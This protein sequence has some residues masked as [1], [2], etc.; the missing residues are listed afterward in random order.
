MCTTVISIDPHSPVP[1]LLLGVRD[2]FLERPWL[3]PGRH[4]PDRPRLVGG[5]DLQARGTWLAVDP[6]APRVACL[7]NGHGEP[8]AQ[9]RRLS[10]GE[11]PLRLASGGE[12]GDLDVSRYDPFHLVCA[13]PDTARLWSWDGRTLAERALDAGLHFIVNSGLEGASGHEEVPAAQMRARIDFYR[14]LFE[15]AARPEPG[16]EPEGRV[17][18]RERSQS[19]LGDGSVESTWGEWLTLAAGAGLDPADPRALVLRRTFDTRQWGTSSLSLVALTR[20]GARFDFCA[21]P[22]DAEPTWSHVL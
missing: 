14:P 11:L 17:R 5:Q 20:T 10:R 8:A 3:P 7:L 19:A 13:T 21:D 15:K 4:W 6:D 1:V 18:T 22:A 2:E 16:T 12:L 9:A